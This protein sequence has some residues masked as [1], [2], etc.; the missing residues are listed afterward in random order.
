MIV[1]VQINS[2]VQRRDFTEDAH[3]QRVK[4]VSKSG[5]IIDRK[6]SHGL[7]FLIEFADGKAWYDQDEFVLI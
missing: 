6:T 7:C 4:F 2:N 3:E 5:K 1:N